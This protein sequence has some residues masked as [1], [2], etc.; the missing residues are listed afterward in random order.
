MLPTT[1][2][3]IWPSDFIGGNFLEINQPQDIFVSDW[4]I[5]ETEYPNEPKFGR[6]TMEGSV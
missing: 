2:L 4:S 1:F 6:K 5:S 3:F